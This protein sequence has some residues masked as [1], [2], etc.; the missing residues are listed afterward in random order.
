MPSLVP[1]ALWAERL[2]VR[3]A[4][5][6]YCMQGCAGFW[7]TLYP[8]GGYLLSTCWMPGIIYCQVRRG[9][10]TCKRQVLTD[11]AGASASPEGQPAEQG[12]SLWG[13]KLGSR[14]SWS[15]KGTRR[16]WL[17]A[18]RGHGGLGSAWATVGGLCIS[19]QG[20]LGS[21]ACGERSPC[22]GSGCGWMG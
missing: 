10:V 6:V 12:S 17:R 11:T 14:R 18:R 13:M 19:E 20:S 16:A 22:S 8:L 3:P 7:E 5:L 21:D 4:A 2:L 15:P 1:A 9:S